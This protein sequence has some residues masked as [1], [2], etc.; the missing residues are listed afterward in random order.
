MRR[1][2]A[3]PDIFMCSKLIK[4]YANFSTNR[5][6]PDY[7]YMAPAH[8]CANFRTWKLVTVLKQQT[9]EVVITTYSTAN[10]PPS[11]MSSV[12][13]VNDQLTHIR[14]T[15]ANAR[16]VRLKICTSFLQ[17]WVNSTHLCESK[18]LLTVSIS[19]SE[20][21]A[22]GVLSYSLVEVRKKYSTS[23]TSFAK[24]AILLLH[25]GR[26]C[27][28]DLM[29]QFDMICAFLNETNVNSITCDWP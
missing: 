26:P 8:V 6:E 14:L 29:I 1:L 16:F 25:L 23:I 24:K 28:T 15:M 10:F 7:K 18:R 3:L 20:T 27:N 4:S 21:V 22:H 5:V 19:L 11:T 9:L 17:M 12:N 13:E 2:Q